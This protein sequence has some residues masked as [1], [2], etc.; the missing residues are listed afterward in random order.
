MILKTPSGD[1]IQ[2][3]GLYFSC[4]KFTVKLKVQGDT[5]IEA[6]PLVH[7]F[8]GQK[9]ANLVSWAKSTFGGPLVIGVLEDERKPSLA[10]LL[11]QVI[12][13]HKGFEDERAYKPPRHRR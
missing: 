1:Q 8:E 2:T 13:E 7:R 5:I 3:L 10:Q 9:L 6:A 12:K 4:P 11:E